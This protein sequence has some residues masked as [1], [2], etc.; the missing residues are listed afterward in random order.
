M[1]DELTV[2][3]EVK[4]DATP[5]VVFEYL[6]DP[7]KLMRW[8][9]SAA[10]FDARPGSDYRFT[11][12]AGHVAAG[13]VVEVRPPT[14]LVYTWGWEG[15]EDVPP[16]SSTVEI[17]LEADGQHTI[18]RLTHRDLPSKEACDSHAEG[19]EHFLPRLSAA[20][21]GAD[22]GP[23]PWANGPAAG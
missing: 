2:M 7:A 3:R 15:N 12:G 8:M 5:D 6:V 14:R 16:G 17:D 11:I 4:V 23:D 22:P 21:S 18:V 20:A 9:P 13:S 10:D 1:A 19:W